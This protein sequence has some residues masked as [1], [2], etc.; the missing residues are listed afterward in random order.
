MVMVVIVVKEGGE[1]ERG[2]GWSWGRRR[3]GLADSM[4]PAVATVD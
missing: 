1:E 4:G 3:H 2:F